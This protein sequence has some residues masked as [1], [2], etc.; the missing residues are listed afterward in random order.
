MKL[1]KT[2]L[3]V[4]IAGI[5]A[6][7]MMASATT[8]LSGAVQLRFSGGDDGVDCPGDAVADADG[9]ITSPS[10]TAAAAAAAAA[11][12]DAPASMLGGCAVNKNNEVVDSGDAQ[13]TAGDVI[14]GVNASQALNSGLTGY[15]NLRIDLDTTSG[16]SI[17][18]ADNVYVGMSGGFGD[19]R[20]GEVANPGEYG[21]LTDIEFDMGTG[22]N[23]GVGYV[24]S[25]GGATVGLSYS[26]TPDHDLYAVGAKFGWNGL[27]IG[28]G[29]QNQDE[30]NNM[31]VGASFAFA[32]ASVGVGALIFEDALPD[33]DDATKDIDETVIQA[34]VGY[35]IA[36]V[37]LGLNFQ[38][39][40][41]AETT[42]I[43]LNAGYDLGGGM[44]V[45]A[46]LDTRDFKEPAEDTT[47][48]RIQ[49]AKSF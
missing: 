8:T 22:I 43:Q 46:R 26:P 2:V 29:L 28:A 30:K 3:A 33:P 4:A 16:E 27:S 11:G 19:L 42:A 44:E 5:A 38:N 17:G 41:E 18:T 25:F 9:N 6:T 39:A 7:P 49:F 24:G 13:I 37:S 48:W 40:Q 31:S 35:S 10:E 12:N 32:G 47:A 20:I 23:Q 21:Q 15:G 36:G 45:S 14:V 1:T 34:T